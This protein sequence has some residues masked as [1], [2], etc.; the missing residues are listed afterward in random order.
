LFESVVQELV[1][2]GLSIPNT[3]KKKLLDFNLGETTLQLY[4]LVWLL[5]DSNEWS[6][7]FILGTSNDQPLPTG[8]KLQIR[9]DK[10]ILS[11]Q[12]INPNSEDAYLYTRVIGE[13]YEKFSAII[14][15]N[16]EE[17]FILP[18]FTFISQQSS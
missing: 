16:P 7:S 6:I 17:P 12:N 15:L 2:Q 4:C 11:E 1:K 3:A 13:P 10:N 5:E 18:Y 14:T 8:L 9:D